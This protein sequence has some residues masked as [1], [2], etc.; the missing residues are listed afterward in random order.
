M[1]TLLFVNVCSLYV[2]FA[3]GCE[4]LSSR[5]DESKDFICRSCGLLSRTVGTEDNVD[6]KSQ[7]TCTEETDTNPAVLPVA[8]ECNVTDD[9]ST[10]PAS[11]DNEFIS[12]TW[13]EG[14]Q[15]IF[16]FMWLGGIVVGTPDFW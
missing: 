12:S 16:V 4:I 8:P 2:C 15:V 11:T 5:L 14:M 6:I 7:V 1:V 10:G 9:A 3:D 13:T